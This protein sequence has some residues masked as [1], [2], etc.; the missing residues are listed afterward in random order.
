MGKVD[1]GH[2]QTVY[3]EALSVLPLIVSYVYHQGRRQQR[4]RR[5]WSTIFGSAPPGAGEGDVAP[6][7]AGTAEA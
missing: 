3:A 5:K 1:T 7:P 2:E 6:T 4:P